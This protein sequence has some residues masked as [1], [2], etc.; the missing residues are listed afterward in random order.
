MYDTTQSIHPMQTMFVGGYIPE[1]H[2]D[3]RHP[4]LLPRE[5]V[6]FIAILKSLR[7]AFGFGRTDNIIG[8][9]V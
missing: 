9:P 1:Q 7:G 8:W 6:D 5:K 2:D 3:D 4:A